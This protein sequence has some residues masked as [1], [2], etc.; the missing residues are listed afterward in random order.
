VKAPIRVLIAEDSATMRDTLVALLGADPRMNVVGC[1]ADGVE[2]VAMAKTLSPHVITMDVLMPRLDGVGA[3][4]AIMAEAPTRILVVSSVVDDKQVDLAFRAIAAGAL[5][6]IGKP[7]AHRSDGLRAWGRSVIDAICLMAEV[8]VVTRRRWGPGFDAGPHGTRCVDAIGIVASTGGPPALAAILGQMPPD[9]P[10]A[11]LIAQHIAERFTDGLVRWLRHVTQLPVSVAR[12]GQPCLAG[13]AYLAP[14]SR[15]LEV[16]P[17][18]LLKLSP[19]S[20]K[21]SPSGDRLL[22]SLAAVYGR[23]CAGIVLTGM[24]DDGA[25][26]LLEIRRA[27]GTTIA[28]SESSCV[29]FGMPKAAAERGGTQ[30]MLPLE[31]IADAIK[32]LAGLGKGQGPG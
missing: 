20:S 3:I 25:L 21:Y 8:P 29:V 5:E 15:D 24:G 12:D 14:D 10:V 11:V 23:R 13:H 9:L 19:P 31:G 17:D 27:G 28:Q 32:E 16:T 18:K 1:A 7:L 6:L 2:A 30:T 4:A 26:G 22:E